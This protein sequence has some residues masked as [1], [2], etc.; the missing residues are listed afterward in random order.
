MAPFYVPVGQ[1][2]TLT[3]SVKNADGTLVTT[4]YD[5]FRWMASGQMTAA[6]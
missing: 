2:L 1:S 4:G 5:E 6:R 3:A